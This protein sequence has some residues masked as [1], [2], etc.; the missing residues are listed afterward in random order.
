MPSPP[1]SSPGQALAL[2]HQNGRGDVSIHGAHR[3]VLFLPDEKTMWRDRFRSI[4]HLESHLHRNGTRIIKFFL[5]I[6]KK[7]QRK[8]F[9]ARLEEPDKNWKF[10]RKDLEERKY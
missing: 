10:N 6:S 5:H 4:R 8:R 1:G 9:L 2:S 7:E 3:A